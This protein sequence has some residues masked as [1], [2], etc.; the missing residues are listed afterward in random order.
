[1]PTPTGYSNTG[2]G[3]NKGTA[4]IFGKPETGNL[5]DPRQTPM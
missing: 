5:N 3:D 2:K 1:M 4:G